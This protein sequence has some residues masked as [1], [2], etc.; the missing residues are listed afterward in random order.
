MMV[1]SPEPPPPPPSC[2]G[3]S[4]DVVAEN[5]LAEGCERKMTQAGRT[6]KRVLPVVNLFE[7]ETSV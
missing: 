6:A 4:R 2:R 5:V 3:A 7:D 1:T